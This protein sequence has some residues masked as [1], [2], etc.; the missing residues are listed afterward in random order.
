MKKQRTRIRLRDE[1]W[2]EPEARASMRGCVREALREAPYATQVDIFILSDMAMRKANRLYRDVDKP[3]DVLSFPAI[4]WQAGEGPAPD[5]DTGRVFLGDVLISID[6]AAAQAA[7]YGHSL[8]RE[9]GFLAV[10]GTL[11]LLG[12]DHETEE[13]RVFMR[14]REEAVLERRGL[15]R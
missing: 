13:G 5:I 12:Y 9:L 6:R 8:A 7:A 11:H 10:H 4:N 15:S 14:A 3:T 2:L 1:H